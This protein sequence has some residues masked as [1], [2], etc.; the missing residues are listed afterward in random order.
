MDSS[1]QLASPVRRKLTSWPACLRMLTLLVLE[2][3]SIPP[4]I[5][6]T[7]KRL[8]GHKM[9]LWAS[10][11]ESEACK[12]NLDPSRT[13]FCTLFLH[14]Q[15]RIDH[16]KSMTLN[17]THFTLSFFSNK[18]CYF[19]REKNISLLQSIRKVHLV[20]EPHHPLDAEPRL[21]LAEQ[22]CTDASWQSFL[23]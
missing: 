21:K 1:K 22:S 4:I 3:E 16:G 20:W 8:R 23:S 6:R 7:V 9:P 13:W 12:L 5:H 18:L 2:D 10:W 17:P 19:V 11:L 14:Y 15:C